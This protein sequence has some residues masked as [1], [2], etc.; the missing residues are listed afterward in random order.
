MW[1]LEESGSLALMNL[2][3]LMMNNDDPDDDDNCDNDDDKELRQVMVPIKL[4]VIENYYG[5]S[6]GVVHHLSSQG[7]GHHLGELRESWEEIRREALQLVK[8]VAIRKLL[9]SE[10]L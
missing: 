8:Q 5:S 10:E 6:Q 3:T 1:T 4:F 7:V 2:P 9:S